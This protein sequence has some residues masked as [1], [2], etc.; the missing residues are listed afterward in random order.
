MKQLKEN[1]LKYYPSFALHKPVFLIIFVFIVVNRCIPT[2]LSAGSSQ[3]TQIFEEV[4]QNGIVRLEA[5]L[6]S[7]TVLDR[8]TVGTGF[9]WDDEL[10]VTCGHL[11]A[12]LK[13]GSKIVGSIN[14]RD[15]HIQIVSI[16][17]KRDVAIFKIP[18]FHPAESFQLRR[19]EKVRIAED[20]YIIGF[21]LPTVIRD[22]NPTVTSGIVSALNRTVAYSNSE[23]KGLI[24]IDAVASDG[25]SG[26]PVLNAE[27]KVIGMVILAASSAQAEW[28][29]AAFALPVDVIKQLLNEKQKKT[30]AKSKSTKFQSVKSLLSGRSK[31]NEKPE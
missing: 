16:D 15:Y 11:V 2:T 9:Y 26:G 5:Q 6:K 24:Q 22:K 14:G 23:I 1:T 3:K 29:G 17:S 28:R 21:P 4:I 8:N 30:K 25:N 18:T 10:W 19:S 20:I 13:P 27:G 12:N 31:N 7:D